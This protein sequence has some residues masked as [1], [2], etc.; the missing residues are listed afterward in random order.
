MQWLG[1]AHFAPTQTGIAM[2]NLTACLAPSDTSFFDTQ[3]GWAAMDVTRTNGRYVDKNMGE[4]KVHGQLALD[5]KRG[6]SRINLTDKTSLGE[7]FDQIRGVTRT[8]QL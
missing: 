1:G 8:T 2:R 5:Q 3:C 7:P 6:Q 4:Q